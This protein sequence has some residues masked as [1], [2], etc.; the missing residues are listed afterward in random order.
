MLWAWSASTPDENRVPG[1]LLLLLALVT[2]DQLVAVELHGGKLEWVAR[3]LPTVLEQRLGA[4][5]SFLPNTELDEAILAVD[6]ADNHPG[7]VRDYLDVAVLLGDAD[8]VRGVLLVAELSFHSLPGE[9]SL[10]EHRRRIV[11]GGQAK[12]RV[13][14][15]RC[16]RIKK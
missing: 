8:Q 3:E 6:H 1:V 9:I 2:L 15:L 10:N 13:E 5:K 7:A 14:W 11:G 12:C 4:E 16:L